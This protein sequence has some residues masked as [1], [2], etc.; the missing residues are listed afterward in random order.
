MLKDFILIPDVLNRGL[1]DQWNQVDSCCSCSVG[2]W[3]WILLILARFV[4]FKFL[5]ETQD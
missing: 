4:T 3:L 2:F 5:S 1:V